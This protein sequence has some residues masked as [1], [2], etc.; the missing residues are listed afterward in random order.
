MLFGSVGFTS[1]SQRREKPLNE[2]NAL[3]NTNGEVRYIKQLK[4]KQ[5]KL[6]VIETEFDDLKVKKESKY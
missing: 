5:Q 1:H 2:A 4:Y 3:H 6:K